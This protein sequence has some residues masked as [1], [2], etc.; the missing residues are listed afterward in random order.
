MISNIALMSTLGLT[1]LAPAESLTACNYQL[2]MV[3]VGAHDER[4]IVEMIG[5]HNKRPDS[6]EL[7]RALSA[8]VKYDIAP[9]EQGFTINGTELDSPRTGDAE[10]VARA[11]TNSIHLHC[12]S[13]YSNDMSRRAE[14]LR[15]LI[16]KREREGRDAAALEEE[17]R[18]VKQALDD[19]EE[20]LRVYKSDEKWYVRREQAA[21]VL[22]VFGA[23]LTGAGIVATAVGIRGQYSATQNLD[24]MVQPDGVDYAARAEAFTY[25]S[26][27]GGIAAASVGFGSTLIALIIMRSVDKQR[28]TN[29]KK[30]VEPKFES[31][32]VSFSETSAGFGV[33]LRF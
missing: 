6:Y 29:A 7:V 25:A 24:S 20:A 22:G 15:E 4:L 13:I 14:E 8:A 21:L 17:L 30:L 19:A 5:E 1:A 16:V 26:I 10:T 12:M 3:G 27:G 18:R 2:D 23:T 28:Q 33:R 32:N 9:S 11:L 31:L